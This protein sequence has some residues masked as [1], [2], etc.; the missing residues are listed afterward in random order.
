MSFF[1]SKKDLKLKSEK[2]KQALKRKQRQGKDAT[3][4]SG[5]SRKKRILVETVVESDEEYSDGN[6]SAPEGSDDEYDN[7]E[8]REFREA[9]ELLAK[10]EKNKKDDEDIGD[11]LKED[12]A[13]RAGT[14]RVSLASLAELRDEEET[15]YRAHRFTPLCV[16]ISPCSKFILS[17]GKESSIV[18]YSLTEK[19]V[20]GVIK[21]TKKGDSEQHAH[22]SHIFAVVISPDGR[23]IASGGADCLVKVWDFKTLQF[24]HE[25]KGHTAPIMSL[26]FQGRTNCLFSGGKDRALRVWDLDQMGLVDTLFGHSDSV[27]SMSALNKARVVTAGAQDRS[28]RLWKIE[29]ESHLIFNAS[30]KHC[31]SMDCVA[32]VNDE[33]FVSGSSSGVVSL[34]T[35]R[36]KKPV[37][38][39]EDAH[40]L[41]ET[42]EPR[43]IVSIA[44]V[45][46]SDFFA[47]GSDDGLLK[48]WKISEDQ[49]RIIQVYEYSI[50]GFIN[51]IVFSTNGRHVCVGA[52]QEHR[53]GR[54]W[55]NKEARNQVVVLPIH[56]G[57]DEE[58]TKEVE[59]RAFESGSDDESDENEENQESGK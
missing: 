18:K 5:E 31:V 19:K 11:L 2:N 37:A 54:W 48:F 35:L 38:V 9:K 50:D 7:V 21:R 33:I 29:D 28:C 8:E 58:E 52:G 30:A 24:L 44:A 27:Q 39:R 43:W 41:R 13:Q 57:N 47:T 6:K 51:S 46:Y 59:E 25:F 53:E 32:M 23:F 45:P 15:S 34:W 17:S 36:R 1:L 40:G 56:Y 10:L 26:C 55:V 12:A 14:L 16:A 42:G 4:N 3:D 20:V 49:R 22:Y